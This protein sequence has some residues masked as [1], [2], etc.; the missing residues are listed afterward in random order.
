MASEL[1]DIE[2][3]APVMTPEGVEVKLADKVI[4]T[5][6]E[7]REQVGRVCATPATQGYGASEAGTVHVYTISPHSGPYIK[8]SVPPGEGPKT[9]RLVAGD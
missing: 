5:N 8:E 2:T 1:S 9:F 7:G 6:T 3:P 4:Y